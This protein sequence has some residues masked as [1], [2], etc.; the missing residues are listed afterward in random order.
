MGIRNDI[1]KE[2]FEKYVPA[3]KMPERNDSVY[4]RM[5]A[6][7]DRAYE[8]LVRDTIGPTF[9]AS[10][11]GDADANENAQAIVCIT[12]FVQTARSLDLVLTATGFGIVRTDS[13]APASRERVDS[14][15]NESR[16]ALYE[17]R[18]VLVRFLS[19]ISGWDV[20]PQAVRSIGNLFWRISL[21]RE[22]T[23]EYTA[24]KWL[25]ALGQSV[26]AD[27]LVRETVGDDLMECLLD[28]LRGNNLSGHYAEVVRLAE[29]VMAVAIS[30]AASGEPPHKRMTDRLTAYVEEHASELPEYME[31]QVYK[32]RHHEGF[33]NEKG[34]STFFFM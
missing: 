8:A 4:K 14:L 11:E 27:R 31:S 17:R 32:A 25:W 34:D 7:F 3:A 15:L 12:A 24:D 28:M 30:K 18:E 10:V 5:E 23:L 9:V 19:G 16:L 2:V 33:K 26:D 22:T 6:A 1:T 20:T 13:T 29:R 21:L